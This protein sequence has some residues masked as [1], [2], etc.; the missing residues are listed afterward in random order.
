MVDLYNVSFVLTQIGAYL[1]AIL[2][3]KEENHTL[4]DSKTKRQPISTKENFWPVTARNK[5]A[6]DMWFKDLAT[7][8]PLN[9]LSKKVRL[10]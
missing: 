5:N 7:S 2:L 10:F 8:K 4:Q 1:N 6:V 9:S 3:K